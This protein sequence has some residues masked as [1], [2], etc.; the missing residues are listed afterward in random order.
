MQVFFHVGESSQLG[1]D[2]DKPWD[3]CVPVLAV[4]HMPQTHPSL[5]EK[6]PEL[7]PSLPPAWVDGNGSRVE[8]VAWR[9]FADELLEGE[10]AAPVL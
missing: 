4:C 6:I 3:C 5:P 9:H 7:K 10:E 8:A 1:K 2:L